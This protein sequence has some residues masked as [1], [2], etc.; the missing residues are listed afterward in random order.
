MKNTITITAVI[1]NPEGKEI[2]RSE[3]NQAVPPDAEPKTFFADMVPP[4]ERILSDAHRQFL[5]TEEEAAQG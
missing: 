5:P 4:I 2:F 1:T 3:H